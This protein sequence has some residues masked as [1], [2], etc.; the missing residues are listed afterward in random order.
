MAGVGDT[1]T[2]YQTY[3]DRAN[4][5]LVYI[6]EAHPGNTVEGRQVFAHQSDDERRGLAQ[7][8]TTSRSLTLPT[9]VD[10]LNNAV[11]VAYAAF[12]DRIYVLDSEG[13]VRYKTA[14]GPRG[15]DVAEP[16]AALDRI[17]K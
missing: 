11:E 9:V 5:L 4:F 3:K 2:W 8:C 12:P 13:V 1:E 6:E 7:L 16:R 17:L 15:W 10:H 14:P